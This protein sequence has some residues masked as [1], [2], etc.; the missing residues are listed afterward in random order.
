MQIWDMLDIKCADRFLINECVVNSSN[1]QG[2]VVL[3]STVHLT[4]PVKKGYLIRIQYVTIANLRNVLHSRTFIFFLLV[5]FKFL[6]V[7]LSPVNV[8]I[9]LR[10]S[11]V[12][13]IKTTC[14]SS[15][16][17]E[18]SSHWSR[19]Y[20]FTTGDLLITNQ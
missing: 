3:Q 1:C 18:S 7:F 2:P 12:R 16:K 11:I 10:K 6:L 14:I 20:P 19:L 17:G 5:W 8:I 13:V 15:E 4:L 9:S